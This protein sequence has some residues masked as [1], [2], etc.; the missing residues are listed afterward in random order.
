M[1][2]QGEKQMAQTK[3]T[4]AARNRKPYY[5][6]KGQLKDDTD[7]GIAMLIAETED[8]DYEPVGTVATIN[9]AR[10]I[11][12]DDMA[13]RMRRLEGGSEPTCP[14]TYKV[15]ARDYQGEYAIACQIEA[16]TLQSAPR[17]IGRRTT[18]S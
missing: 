8:G 11:A 16:A 9:E 10:E 6:F 17:S 18:I 7:L 12:R 13:R 4:D 3:Q 14:A 5:P 15:W 2:V 1:G